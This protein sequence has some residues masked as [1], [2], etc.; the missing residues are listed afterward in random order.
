MDSNPAILSEELPSGEHFCE[1]TAN[2]SSDWTKKYYLFGL[3][4]MTEV[5]DI[6]GRYDDP[7]L[8]RLGC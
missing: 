4:S 5:D 8:L 2:I 7:V 1:I 3:T 6:T